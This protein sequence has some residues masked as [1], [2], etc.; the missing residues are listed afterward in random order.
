MSGTT[1]NSDERTRLLTDP[2]YDP[3]LDEWNELI[4]EGGA[5]Y[6]S[7]LPSA[8]STSTAPSTRASTY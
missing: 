3:S 2:T 6:K 7:E 1:A 5:A 4:H 8:T